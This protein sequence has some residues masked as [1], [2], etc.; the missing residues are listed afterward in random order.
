MKW[1]GQRWAAWVLVG[2]L[3]APALAQA[4]K[5]RLDTVLG[6]VDIELYD[7]A[8]PLT[9]ANFLAY[10]RS[11]AY[12]NSFIHRSAKGFVIQGGGYTWD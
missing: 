8:A 1:G 3:M 10:V 6:P 2:L 4:T 5:V 12:N 7:D 9:V 11:G